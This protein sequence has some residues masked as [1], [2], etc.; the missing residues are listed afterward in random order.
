MFQEAE[1]TLAEV[2]DERALQFD[3]LQRLA[4]DLGG[5]SS[6]LNQ[7][8]TTLAGLAATA[9]GA[10]GV[11]ANR[12]A[13]GGLPAGV[14]T[15]AGALLI[16]AALALVMAALLSIASVIPTPGWS[17]TFANWAHEVAAGRLTKEARLTHLDLTI[18][19]QLA[20]NQTK[21]HRMYWAYVALAVAL[22]T[23][24]LAVALIT[25]DAV[26]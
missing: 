21:A 4:N 10:L 8:A 16:A 24:A 2:K 5:G 3:E 22:T 11:F 14:L 26:S 18:K 15:A 7:R 12:L 17:A 6:S 20:R 25:A 1:P 13:E 9:L 23:T 19:R